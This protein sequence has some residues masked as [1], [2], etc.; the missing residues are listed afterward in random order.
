M[1]IVSKIKEHLVPAVLMTGLYALVMS[2]V[3][4]VFMVIRLF[5]CGC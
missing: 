1:R 2:A 3:I 4:A 5:M